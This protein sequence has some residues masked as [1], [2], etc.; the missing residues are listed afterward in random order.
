MI[1]K[2][3]SHDDDIQATV[4]AYFMYLHLFDLIGCEE[5]GQAVLIDPAIIAAGRGNARLV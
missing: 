5:A 3:V 1:D 4:R 2:G